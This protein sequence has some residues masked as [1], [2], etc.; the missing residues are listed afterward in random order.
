MRKTILLLLLG[1]FFLIGCQGREKENT[2]QE[3]V[4]LTFAQKNENLDKVFEKENTDH[5]EEMS[6]PFQRT[7]NAKQEEGVQSPI[8]RNENLGQV[9]EDEYTRSPS[10]PCP[11]EVEIYPASIT[12][13]DP[14]YVRLNFHNNTDMNTYVY[15]G[16][17][18]NQGMAVRSQFASFYLKEITGETT[19]WKVYTGVFDG[20]TVFTFRKV[21]I[22]EKGP[23]Q[24]VAFD[25]PALFRPIGATNSISAISEERLEKIQSRAPHVT[26]GQLLVV[27]INSRPNMYSGPIESRQTLT[28]TS[29]QFTIKAR[30]QDEMEFLNE[31]FFNTQN[32]QQPHLEQIIAKTSPGTLQNLMKFLLLFGEVSQGLREESED[33]ILKALDK[34]QNFLLT[35]HEIERENLKRFIDVDTY[36][37][38]RIRD[39]E[40]LLERFTEVFDKSETQTCP[41]YCIGR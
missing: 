14:L 20:N 10:R 28:V 37:V 15:A 35:L 34:L 2:V 24:Y 31:T 25:F 39:H 16:S 40:K 8:Q 19:P 9:Q 11:F 13:G 27:E 17:L 23:A 32:R 6:D 33:Q 30:D 21:A 4:I 1:C 22:G 29:P 26:T 38:G 5:D 41:G 18:H 12:I 36:V 3:E 7:K